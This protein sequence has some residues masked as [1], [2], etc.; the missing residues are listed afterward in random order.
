VLAEEVNAEAGQGRLEQ[1]K[2]LI[3]SKPAYGLDKN[4][5]VTMVE[6]LASGEQKSDNTE[7]FNKACDARLVYLKAFSDIYEPDNTAAVEDGGVEALARALEG[8][9]GE[10]D[11]ELNP[12]TAPVTQD[13][14]EVIYED[15]NHSQEHKKLIEAY[16]TIATEMSKNKQEPG[17][18]ERKK[19]VKFYFSKKISTSYASLIFHGFGIS[20]AMTKFSFSPIRLALN[21]DTYSPYKK[22]DE[23]LDKF[24]EVYLGGDQGK[25]NKI[26]VRS[27]SIINDIYFAERF[28]DLV[29]EFKKIKDSQNQKEEEIFKELLKPKNL[30]IIVWSFKDSKTKELIAILSNDQKADL[31]T[32]I[33]KIKKEN[34]HHSKFITKTKNVSV[35]LDVGLSG[36]T[37]SLVSCFP[38]RGL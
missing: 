21:P 13:S 25:K 35:D 10:G 8:Q 19:F 15:E 26:A 32:E 37:A 34:N 5:K 4:G 1:P 27:T 22:L 24:N 17:A 30:E 12:E 3:K 16:K 7:E 6:D 11:E 23:M 28:Y 33:D 38:S 29:E 18:D 36:A 20:K 2:N 9:A 31:K 14:P